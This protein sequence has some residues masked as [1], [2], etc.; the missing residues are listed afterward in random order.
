MICFRVPSYGLWNCF[1]HINDVQWVQK[2]VDI[3]AIEDLSS[4]RSWACSKHRAPRNPLVDHDFHHVK[5]HQLEVKACIL[6]PLTCCHTLDEVIF[7]FSTSSCHHAAVCC[8]VDMQDPCF[9]DQRL[10][11][12]ETSVNF[13][14][15]NPDLGLGHLFKH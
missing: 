9:P 2:T 10:V 1:A 11:F 15:G 6:K 12:P 4:F 8:F 13:C 3:A 7:F 5:G 14:K